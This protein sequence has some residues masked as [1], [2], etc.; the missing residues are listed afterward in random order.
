MASLIF[1]FFFAATRLVLTFI[2]SSFTQP[3]IHLD[4]LRLLT[5]DSLAETYHQL[6]LRLTVDCLENNQVKNVHL[7]NI[8]WFY[9]LVL[10]I[11]S[12]LIFKKCGRSE[13]INPFYKLVRK[14][15]QLVQA[16]N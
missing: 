12:P 16:S 4:T 11:I 8:L 10:Y 3:P 6:D 1:F 2:S 15:T 9:D 5:D 14:V 13:I 7:Y